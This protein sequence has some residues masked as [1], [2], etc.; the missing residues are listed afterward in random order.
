MSETVMGVTNSQN[1][2][3]VENEVPL[4]NSLEK[5]YMVVDPDG[6]RNHELLH[7]RGPT[8]I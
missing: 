2:P 1:P 7:W 3:L 5:K 6:I 4:Q 8:T